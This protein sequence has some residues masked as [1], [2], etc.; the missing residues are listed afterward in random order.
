MTLKCMKENY[1]IETSLLK[2]SETVLYTSLLI[3]FG[4]VGV[5]GS[6]FIARYIN[7]NYSIPIIIIGFLL[8]LVIPVVY[9]SKKPRIFTKR[10]II[11]LIDQSIVI[12]ILDRKSD[13]IR[14]HYDIELQNL[15]SFKIGK[16]DYNNTSFLRLIKK[17]GSRVQFSF[18]EQN[19]N[20]QNVFKNLFSFLKDYNVGKAENEKIILLPNFYNTKSGR[21]IINGIAIL[22]VVAVILLILI[23]PEAIPFGLLVG[24]FFFARIKSQQKKD[25]ELINR[26]Q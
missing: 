4:F 1:H 22:I 12:D 26:F 18:F 7:N 14:E 11:H 15:N 24:I 9:I 13:L 25:L 16:A 19:D 17:D 21:L 5:S 6:I 10:A 8:F 2:E 23:K 20:G 3:A